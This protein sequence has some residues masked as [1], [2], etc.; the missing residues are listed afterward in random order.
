VADRKEVQTV[1]ELLTWLQAQIDA[2]AL[3]SEAKIS[4]PDLYGTC[5][6]DGMVVM[7]TPGGIPVDPEPNLFQCWG[8]MS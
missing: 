7:V 3:T 1:G 5:S 8:P 2:G 6:R 4:C